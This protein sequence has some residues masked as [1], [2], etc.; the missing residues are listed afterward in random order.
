MTRRTE[1]AWMRHPELD[2]VIQVVRCQV[3]HLGAA[4]WY[5]VDPPPPPKPKPK[6]Q[7]QAAGAAADSAPSRRAGRPS[8]K[9]TD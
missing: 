9:G 7:Q 3:P 6:R 5:E 4:G 8:E 2:R 1:P